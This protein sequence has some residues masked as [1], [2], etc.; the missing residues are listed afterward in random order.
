MKRHLLLSAL[1]L[2]IV[3]MSPLQA[4]RS[5]VRNLTSNFAIEGVLREPFEVFPA[6]T[7]ITLQRFITHKGNGETLRKGV[8]SINGKQYAIPVS[9]MKQMKEIIPN[10]RTNSS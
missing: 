6:G 1:I 8:I 7:P 9:E 10:N 4:Q 5:S 3:G 2:L